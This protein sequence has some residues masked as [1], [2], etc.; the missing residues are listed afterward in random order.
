[1]IHFPLSKDKAVPGC[2][3]LFVHQ[4][5]LLHFHVCYYISLILDLTY[6]F[7]ITYHLPT[8]LYLS[9]PPRWLITERWWN[10]HI[11]ICFS[12]G[13]A[14]HVWMNYQKWEIGMWSVQETSNFFWKYLGIW[15]CAKD[16]SISHCVVLNCLKMNNENLVPVCTSVT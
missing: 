6:L 7:S 12:S 9:S 13:H 14:G 11:L 2:P 4:G 3:P 10:L 16:T 8:V 15:K 5:Q 1:M